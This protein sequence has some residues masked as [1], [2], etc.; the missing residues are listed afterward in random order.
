DW[1]RAQAAFSCARI[2]RRKARVRGRLPAIL[3][4]DHSR[5]CFEQAFEESQAVGAAEEGIADAF[6][7]RHK[8][9]HVALLVQDAGDVS[10]RSIRI[11][12]LGIAEHD[13]AIAF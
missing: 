11:V 1:V 7:V 10:R 9:E 8:S 2:L 3:R 5:E 6:G 13:A 4:L 12:T